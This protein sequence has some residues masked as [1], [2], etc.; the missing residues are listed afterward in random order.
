MDNPEAA[1]GLE[2]AIFQA[3]A[4]VASRPD[5]GLKSELDSD[6]ETL[7]NDPKLPNEIRA[8]IYHMRPLLRLR[9]YHSTAD[10]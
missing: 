2:A 8:Y 1:D 9:L 3:C 5:L 7:K 10:A 4:R 6:S